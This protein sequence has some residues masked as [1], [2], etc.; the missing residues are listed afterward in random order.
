MT[1][2]ALPP[3]ADFLT[4]VR[5]L[6]ESPSKA[7]LG[8]EVQRFLNK[9]LTGD[10]A[11][12]TGCIGVLLSSEASQTL[13]LLQLP[14]LPGLSCL[15]LPLPIQGGHRG[16]ACSGWPFSDSFPTFQESQVPLLVN[17]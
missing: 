17:L 7:G 2:R 1:R 5:H 8:R 11:G 4:S 6:W 15:L 10:G 16:A 12:G 14:V 13:P 9:A 3:T